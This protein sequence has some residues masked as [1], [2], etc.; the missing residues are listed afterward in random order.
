MVQ[1]GY[2]PNRIDLVLL[3]ESEPTFT[4]A[5]ERAQEAAVSGVRVRVVSKD[6]LLALKRSFGRA[7]D[8]ADASELEEE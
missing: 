5:Y 7:H 2:A 8:L 6:D 3:P 1:L 4:A